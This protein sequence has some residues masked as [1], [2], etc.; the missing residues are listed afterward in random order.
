[1]PPSGFTPDPLVMMNQ[2]LY[3][4]GIGNL[5]LGVG[6]ATAMLECAITLGAS[7]LILALFRPR[8]S[9]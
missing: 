2:V 1:M 5:Q 8:W 6:S 7:L 3:N 9:Y 4:I